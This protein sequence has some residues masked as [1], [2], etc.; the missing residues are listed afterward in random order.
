[1]CPT[2]FQVLQIQ[3]WTR[4][5][6]R[7]KGAETS[8]CRLLFIPPAGSTILPSLYSWGWPLVCITRAPHLLAS[9]FNQLLWL[10]R[11]KPES[12]LAFDPY[13]KH[14]STSLRPGGHSLNTKRKPL[15][16]LG[17]L[18]NCSSIIF[19]CFNQFFLPPY[20][21]SPC[22]PAP[23]IHP[24]MRYLLPQR[25]TAEPKGQILC[26]FFQKARSRLN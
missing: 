17:A 1:M 6:S 7:A 26:F 10:K 15:R 13:L 25:G 24:D 14:L 5:C 4:P 20:S 3:P 23:F 19:W 18:H 12:H 16:P 11:E 8:P 9:S 21:Q 22:E 2:L